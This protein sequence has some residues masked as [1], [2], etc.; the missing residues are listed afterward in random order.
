[1]KKLKNNAA[2]WEKSTIFNIPNNGHDKKVSSQFYSEPREEECGE[3]CRVR[4]HGAEE[5]NVS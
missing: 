3:V 2:F 5:I 1:M 4:I